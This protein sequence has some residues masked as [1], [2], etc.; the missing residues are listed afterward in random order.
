MIA[1]QVGIDVSGLIPWINIV[2]EEL[3]LSL[4]DGTY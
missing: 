3:P 1:F 4:K 2:Q